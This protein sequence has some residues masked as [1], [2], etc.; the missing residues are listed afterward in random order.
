MLFN[1]FRKKDDVMVDYS[2]KDTTKPSDAT[3]DTPVPN[4][5]GCLEVEDVFSIK[6]RGTVVTGRV[7]G[8][9][10]LNDDAVVERI[11]GMTIDT[12]ILGIEAFH[13]TLDCASEG[14]NC[15]LLLQGI[16]RNQVDRGDFIKT[17]N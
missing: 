15:G 11:G 14:D 10:H 16:D 1:L 13:K 2:A 9:F 5:P 7:R 8:C 4:G 6:G 12:K 3:M 17:V